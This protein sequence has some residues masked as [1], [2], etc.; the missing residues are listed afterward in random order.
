MNYR[1]NRS[2][3]KRYILVTFGYLEVLNE[4]KNTTNKGG[5]VWRVNEGKRGKRH[6]PRN[7]SNKGLYTNK[8]TSRAKTGEL[9]YL[10]VK[11]GFDK[12]CISRAQQSHKNQWDDIQE[13][14][15]RP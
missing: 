8:R 15:I 13:G 9:E 6:K 2:K 14:Q 7:R 1:E 5:R 3:W 4:K 10:P 12:S 11:E